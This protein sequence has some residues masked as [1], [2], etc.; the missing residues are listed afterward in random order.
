MIF[1]TVLAAALFVGLSV[2]PS[3]AENTSLPMAEPEAAGIDPER[4]EHLVSFVKKGIDA[5]E[6]PGLVLLVAR[7]GK[8]VLH[9]AYGERNPVTKE[10]MTTDSIFR[11]YSMGKLIA[12]AAALRLIE[13]GELGFDTAVPDVLPEFKH[14]RVV[15]REKPGAEHGTYATIEAISEI[16]V[17]DLLRHSAGFGGYNFYPGYVGDLFRQAGIGRQDLSLAEAAEKT[18]KL[19]LEYQPGTTFSYAETSYNTLGRVLE[20][21]QGK[22]LEDILQAEIFKSVGMTQTGFEV[23]SDAAARL[24]ERMKTNRDAIEWFDAAGPRKFH[25]PATGMVSTAADFWRFTQMLLDNGRSLDGQSVLAPMTVDTM[26]A[27]NTRGLAQGLMPTTDLSPGF[28]WGL[29]VFVSIPD[30][31]TILLG[32]AEGGLFRMAADGGTSYITSREHNFVAVF[33]NPQVEYL[34]K[35]HAILAN[36]ALQAIAD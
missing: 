10:P 25:S 18:A 9:E 11:I 1:R 17:A 21:N 22:P 13:R 26:L 5:G 20:V 29:G 8:V 24:A 35:N 34:K 16:T 3:L 32:G 12:S 31:P 33:M 19:P 15:D 4:L 23:P 14:M 2:A 30:E 6:T 27:N 36:L 28:A 7:N